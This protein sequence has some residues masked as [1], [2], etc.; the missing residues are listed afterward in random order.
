MSK[1]WMLVARLHSANLTI[2]FCSVSGSCFSDTQNL[3]LAQ[4][5]TYPQVSSHIIVP[6]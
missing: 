5:Q 2:G 4:Q 3:K 6:H 1:T